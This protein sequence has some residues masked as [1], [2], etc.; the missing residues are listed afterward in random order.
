MFRI[1]GAFALISR[2][3]SLSE[4]T[5]SAPYLEP[6]EDLKSV[7]LDRDSHSS[8]LHAGSDDKIALR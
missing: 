7:H 5:L 4:S 8:S 6:R 3:S 1:L 2:R